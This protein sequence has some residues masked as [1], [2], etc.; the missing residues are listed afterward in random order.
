LLP[1]IEVEHKE[2]TMTLADHLPP[3]LRGPATTI[4]RIAAGLSGAGVYRVEAAGQSFVL[5]VAAESETVADW[6]STLDVQQL[7]AAAGL[8]PRV[9]YVDGPGRA[10]LT[11]FVA[12]RSFTA[13]YLDPRTRDAAIAQLGSTVRRIHALPVP[14][15]APRRDPREFLTRIWGGFRADLAL[16]D[17]AAA[18]VQRVLAAEPPVRE[19]AL[20]LGHNDLNPTNLVYDGEAILVLDWAAAGPADAFYDLAVLA[21]F[22]RM[23]EGTSLRLLSAYEDRPLAGLPASFLHARRLAAALAGAF[24]LQLAFQMKHPGATGMETAEGTSSLGDFYQRL[25]AGALTLG[26]ADG[27]WAFGLALLK[28]AFAL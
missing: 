10:V 8:T 25:R 17:F 24:Q 15:A 22:L 5:K 1:A 23:D 4:T 27:H 20:V 21:V 3:D 14:A 12:D 26:T 11:A 19:S 16:P 18:T 2:S 28:E 6:Q 9:V 13:F 7:A